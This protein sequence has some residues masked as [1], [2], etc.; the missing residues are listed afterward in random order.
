LDSTKIQSQCEP[1]A[2]RPGYQKKQDRDRDESLAAVTGHKTR[3]RVEH[4]KM[5]TL[6][7][8]IP[9]KARNG[10]SM[11]GYTSD[12]HW[13]RRTERRP[14]NMAAIVPTWQQSYR[15][16]RPWQEW[17]QNNSV[18]DI[19]VLLSLTLISASRLVE[20][21]LIAAFCFAHLGG[22]V[23]CLAKFVTV[24]SRVGVVRIGSWC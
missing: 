19:G 3:F 17:S 22:L 13:R 11:W 21:M 15:V 23:I 6:P 12:V 20:S 14:K 7:C 10:R 16:R 4:G 2:T 18:D 8:D 24:A 9:S 1:L 5:C